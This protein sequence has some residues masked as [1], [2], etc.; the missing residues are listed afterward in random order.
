MN[1][2]EKTEAHRT[3]IRKIFI[4]SGFALLIATVGILLSSTDDPAR[5]VYLDRYSASRFKTV[6]LLFPLGTFFLFLANDLKARAISLSKLLSA[7][8][9]GSSLG[10]LGLSFILFVHNVSTNDRFID[11]TPQKTNE[12]LY[13]Y[14]WSLLDTDSNKLNSSFSIDD[15]FKNFRNSQGSDGLHRP[16]WISWISRP[17]SAKLNGWFYTE[18]GWINFNVTTFFVQGLIGLFLG[19]MCFVWTKSPLIG[20]GTTILYLTSNDFSQSIMYY[21]RIVKPLLVIPS[22]LIAHQLRLFESKVLPVGDLKGKKLFSVSLLFIF[23]YGLDEYAW[24]IGVIL[25]GLY[26]LRLTNMGKEFVSNYKDALKKIALPSVILFCSFVL[27]LI[28]YFSFPPPLEVTKGI[29]TYKNPFSSRW[30]NLIRMVPYGFPYYTDTFLYNWGGFPAQRFLYKFILLF[31]YIGLM[32]GFFFQIKKENKLKWFS[33][34]HGMMMF[35]IM[36]ILMITAMKPGDQLWNQ[37]YYNAPIAITVPVYLAL[38][39]SSFEKKALIKSLVILSISIFSLLNTKMFRS[40]YLEK[41]NSYN[42][43]L[44]KKLKDIRKKVVRGE[45]VYLSEPLEELEFNWDWSKGL[46]IYRS[47]P[48]NNSPETFPFYYY[49]I[50]KWIQEGKVILAKKDYEKFFVMKQQP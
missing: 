34:F 23:L 16:R 49:F 31:T 46:I 12:Y 43:A 3:L 39:A 50:T 10:I 30:I 6:C 24:P 4:G 42:Y 37:Y 13:T 27:V 9:K 7:G 44:Y 5:A 28:V 32:V 41:E 22:L 40:E 29:D 36:C 21:H 15:I 35:L 26:C 18:F 14:H 38:L 47:L 20:L 25:I 8:I 11:T 17:L 48:E 45:K 19:L 1:F 33:A 2:I